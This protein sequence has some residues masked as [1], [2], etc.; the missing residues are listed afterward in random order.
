MNQDQSHADHISGLSPEAFSSLF[1]A[2]GGLR[3][4][5]PNSTYPLRNRPS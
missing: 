2:I 5:D 3:K 4:D 1:Q